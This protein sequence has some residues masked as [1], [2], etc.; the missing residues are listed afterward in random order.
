MFCRRPSLT[1][2]WAGW[3]SRLMKFHFTLVSSPALWRRWALATPLV[4]PLRARCADGLPAFLVAVQRFLCMT[5][6][7]AACFYH[8]AAGEQPHLTPLLQFFKIPKLE[9]DPY[10]GTFVKMI[11]YFTHQRSWHKWKR[12][13]LQQQFTAFCLTR[14]HSHERRH[15]LIAN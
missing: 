1:F 6:S 10:S 9:V 15:M 12:L 3:S 2:H 8:K 14:P 13:V 4:P 11:Y 5:E 7:G